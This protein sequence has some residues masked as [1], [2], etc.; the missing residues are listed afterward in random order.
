[1][2]YGAWG[3][4]LESK[5]MS[6]TSWC[7]W[8]SYP[9]P[10]HFLLVWHFSVPLSPAFQSRS[11]FKLSSTILLLLIWGCVGRN[12]REGLS[13]APASSWPSSPLFIYNTFH[14]VILSVAKV[15]ATLILVFVCF[16]SFF[17]AASN[18][19]AGGRTFFTFVLAVMHT[20]LAVYLSQNSLI[21]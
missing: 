13:C 9:V 21:N 18:L 17:E 19:G 16:S 3:P 4:E 7:T 11:L 15:F 14:V 10:L 6:L 8:S 5:W 2:A 20:P 12:S 1:M